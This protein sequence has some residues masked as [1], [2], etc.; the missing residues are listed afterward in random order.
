MIL[1]TESEGKLKVMGE[2]LEKIGRL[3]REAPSV[4]KI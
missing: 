2:I 3:A 4:T 1:K